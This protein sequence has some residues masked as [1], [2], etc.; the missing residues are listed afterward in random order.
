MT[1][2][3]SMPHR[4]CVRFADATRT[5]EFDVEPLD[6]GILFYSSD[7]K[8]VSGANGNDAAA[9]DQVLEWLRSKFSHVEVDSS[10]KPSF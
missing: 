7:P 3:I 8:L 1:V 5:L 4:Y 9:A 2:A 6:G 10:A